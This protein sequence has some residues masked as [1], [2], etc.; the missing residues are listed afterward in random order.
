MEV[1]TGERELDGGKRWEMPGLRIGYL[2]QEVTPKAGQTVYEFIFSGLPKDKQNDD[3]A[4]MVEMMLS[5][6]ELE[7]LSA[8]WEAGWDDGHEEFQ[9]NNKAST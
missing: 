9:A 3:Y 2:Q 5:P 7:V 4:Y 1:I 8:S 6:F